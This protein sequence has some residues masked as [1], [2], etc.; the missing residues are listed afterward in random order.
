MRPMKIYMLILFENRYEDNFPSHQYC[1]FLLYHF[2][3]YFS[4]TLPKVYFDLT[5]IQA[6][7]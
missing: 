1:I 6:T 4:N 2:A 5:A 7:L 3:L